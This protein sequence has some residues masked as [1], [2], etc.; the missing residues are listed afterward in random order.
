MK[1]GD[2]CIVDDKKK[3][4]EMIIELIEMNWKHYIYFTNRQMCQLHLYIM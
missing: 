1:D 4:I 2:G 3:D